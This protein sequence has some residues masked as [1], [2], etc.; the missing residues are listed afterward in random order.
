MNFNYNG[1]LYEIVIEKKKIKNTYIK[2]KEDLKIYVST[3]YLTP[4]FAIKKLIND[5]EK[6]IIKMIEIQEN[7]K[8]KKDGY[9]L[10]GD[11]KS[12]V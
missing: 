1:K 7:K 5:S 12:V 4:K 11:R 2:V 6:Q 8:S 9:Y 3:S 10:L